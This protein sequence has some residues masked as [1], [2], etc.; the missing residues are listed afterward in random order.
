MTAEQKTEQEVEEGR[1]N[2]YLQIKDK[3]PTL[4]KPVTIVLPDQAEIFQRWQELPRLTDLLGYNRKKKVS[5]RDLAKELLVGSSEKFFDLAMEMALDHASLDKGA[6]LLSHVIG[7]L[8]KIENG[9]VIKHDQ[10]LMSLDAVME[11]YRHLSVKQAVPIHDLA[12]KVAD[13]PVTL[14]FLLAKPSAEAHP[15]Q[16]TAQKLLSKEDVSL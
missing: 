15:L 10:L 7:E 9:V 6:T 3:I 16:G 4:K 13:M 1:Q 2:F 14:D 11:V 8:R 5:V 12:K